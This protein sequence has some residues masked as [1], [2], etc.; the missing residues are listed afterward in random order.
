ML[1]AAMLIGGAAAAVAV[2][3]LGAW[4]YIRAT[5]ETPAHETLAADGPFELRA[6]P[7]MTVA[8]TERGGPR[9]AALRAGFRPLARYI[10]ASERDGD[11]IAMTAPV[12]QAPGGVGW[13]VAFVMPAD[14]ARDALPAPGTDAVR[15]VDWPPARRAAVRF[16]GAADDD[17]L[18]EREAALR[19]WIAERGLTPLGPA[20]HAYY[21]D[22]M[23]PGF[24]RRNEIL[25]EVGDGAAAG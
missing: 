2:L 1:K 6:Y 18:A 13:R 10:F 5:I 23:T 21:D 9:R 20:V 17:L 8:E 22:P 16:A 12:L 24:L 11:K 25:I 7:A 3:G 14:A 19:A 4:A 15:L